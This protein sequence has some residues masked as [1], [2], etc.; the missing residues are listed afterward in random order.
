MTPGN[1]YTCTNVPPSWLLIVPA[2]VPTLRT[3]LHLCLAVFC[4]VS[5]LNADFFPL[6]SAF[7][8]TVSP[9]TVYKL[10]DG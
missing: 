4:A 5:P 6:F 7:L 10:R 2:Y 3:R 1:P 9:P 8:F